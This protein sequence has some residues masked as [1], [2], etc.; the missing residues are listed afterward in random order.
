M[1]REKLLEPE[2]GSKDEPGLQFGWS[3]GARVFPREGF[4]NHSLIGAFNLGN[5]RGINFFGDSDFFQRPDD[6]PVEIN[7]VPGE[8]VARGDGMRMMIVV[9]AFAPGYQRHP[10]AIGG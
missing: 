2:A 7:L 3:Q 5:F 6:V 4:G 1:D 9:P 8:A 10:P